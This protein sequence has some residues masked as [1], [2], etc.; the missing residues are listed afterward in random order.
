MSYLSVIFSPGDADTRFL[1]DVATMHQRT[2]RHT[3]ENPIWCRLRWE[4]I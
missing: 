3:R 1:P 2:L 4:L